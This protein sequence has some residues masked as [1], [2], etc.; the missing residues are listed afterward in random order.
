M[1]TRNARSR[2]RL[3]PHKRLAGSIVLVLMIVLLSFL[4]ITGGFENTGIFWFSTFPLLAFF[5]KG[6]MEGLLWISFL[7]LVEF[8]VLLLHHWDFLDVPYSSETLHQ[9]FF[10]FVIVSILAFSYEYTRELQANQL[11]KVAAID[12]LTKAYNRSKITE[13][14][15]HEIEMARRYKIDLSLV[16]FDLDHFKEI[17]DSYGHQVGDFVLESITS[18]LADRFT[19]L[20]GEPPMRYLARWRIQVAAHQLRNSDASLARIAVQV[21]YESEAAFNRAFKRSFGVP[22]ATWRRNGLAVQ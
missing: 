7:L 5:L 11:K 8:I 1:E 21:G 17:N 19:R 12:A 22:P 18:T 9:A 15:E 20:I 2:L 14:L 3:N 6:K 13:V 16:M 4:L 10:S